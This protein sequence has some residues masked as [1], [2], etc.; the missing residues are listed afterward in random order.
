MESPQTPENTLATVRRV[1]R[2]GVFM[3]LGAVVGIIV[4]LIL[5][6]AGSFEPTP[7]GEVTYSAG[8]VFGFTLLYL[9]PIGIALGAVVAMLLE[10]MTRR[11]DRVVRVN[12][13]RII[14]VDEH[15]AEPEAERDS[16]QGDARD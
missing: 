13:E 6:F 1:P 7:G 8:Q 4:A 12:H 3:G 10:R 5:T 15:D 9:V 14:T 16:E 11:H 2:Y